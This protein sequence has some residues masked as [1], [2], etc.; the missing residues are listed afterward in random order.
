MPPTL[1]EQIS[2]HLA[3]DADVV[4]PELVSSL[5]IRPHDMTSNPRFIHDQI[6]NPVNKALVERTVGEMKDKPWDEIYAVLVGRLVA[7]VFPHISGRVLAQTLPSHAYDTDYIVNQ[8]RGYIKAMNAEGIPTDRA[9]IKLATTSAGVH[10]AVILKKEGIATLGTCLFSL[11]QAIAA[12]QSGMYAISMYFNDP[13]AATDEGV[14]PDVEDPATQHPM[15][16]RHARI[17]QVYDRLA[18]EGKNAPQMKTASFLSIREVIAMIDLGADHVTLGRPTLEDLTAI[19]G[20]P[21]YTP[22]QWKVPISSQLSQPHFQYNT[23]SAPE[24]EAIKKGQIAISKTDPYSKVMSD[25][26]LNASTGIDYLADGVLDKANEEDEVTRVR[27]EIA[28]KRFGVFEEES[29]KEIE[30]VRKEVA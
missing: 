21:T 10:A 27:L 8:A 17:R 5:P 15:A 4:D 30:R 23:W 9:C 14:W 28:L 24:S 1:L 29:R 3:I 19:S 6:V 22:G 18:K 11:H 2:K 13:L 12:S 7:R 25:D 20:L 26:W 16:A